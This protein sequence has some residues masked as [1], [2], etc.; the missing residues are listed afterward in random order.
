MVL[1][2]RVYSETEL[3][4][5]VEF[6][7]GINIILGK[8][9]GEKEARGVNGIGKSTLIRLIDFSFLSTQYTKKLFNARKY[10]FLTGHNVVLDFI[11][12][13]NTYTIKRYFENPEIV[14]F[15]SNNSFD[16]YNA[17]ELKLILGRIFFKGNSQVTFVDNKWFRKLIKFF[18][19][20]DLNQHER[21]DPVNF[22]AH[23]SRKFELLTYNFYL[24]G[25]PNLNILKFDEKAQEIRNFQKTKEYLEKKITEEIGK[26]VGEIKTELDTIHSR[27]EILQESLK[28]Y[29][30]LKNYQDIEEM[31]LKITNK[32]N[33]H[34]H[35][36]AA[37]ERKLNDYQD[38]YRFTLE[39]D[40]DKVKRIYN[41]IDRNVG[42]FVKRSLEEVIQ[43][44]RAIAEN[45]KK[46][47]VEK[48]REL[49]ESIELIL[50]KISDL[51]K[52]RSK[53]YKMID[54]QEA[55]DS[56]KNTYERLIEEKSNYERNIISV[57]K[58]QDLELSIAK[59]DK[60][61]AEIIE[62]IIVD[63]DAVEK[64]IADLR[65]LYKSIL[66]EAIFVDES[67]EGGFFDIKARS[68]RKAPVSIFV[69]I[70]KSLSFGNFRFEI[71]AYDLTV[72]I[73]LI[74]KNRELPHFLI[75]DG[76]FHGI[77]PKAVVNVLNYMH[78]QNLIYHNFQYIIT[79]NEDEI[80]F[81]EDKESIYG[82]YNF[83]FD[84]S[85]IASYEDIPEKMIFKREFR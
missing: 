80:L 34:L 61:S 85:K 15:G 35:V 64:E 30:F 71:L 70:P 52:E 38:V 43:F 77:S 22:L 50:E 49:K 63:M 55:L 48:E 9:S 73:N 25:L 66:R 81:S 42:E 41:D 67:T 14:Y 56:I 45:R 23:Y 8:Y 13:G 54:E 39:I 10:D 26:S 44:R 76:V 3:F 78:S 74:A 82:K 72:F 29:K 1:L 20:D 31:I 40:L 7:T 58:L 36:Y 84:E 4:D 75:H 46:F 51:E 16:E 69:D 47:L 57:N 53:L 37:L 11:D 17:E 79:A 68:N 2:K 5:E 59:N 6:H 28:E 60:I 62:D 32:I 27:I 83:N 18:V 12:G 65:L 33:Q 21:G 19:K 24:L